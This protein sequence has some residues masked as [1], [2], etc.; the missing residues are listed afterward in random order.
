MTSHFRTGLMAATLLLAG[1]A[2]MAP[3]NDERR[4]MSALGLPQLSQS[5][6]DR[7]VAKAAAFPLGSKDNPV[8]ADGALGQRAYLTRLR[9]S[10]GR[11]PT[12][13]RSGNLG[14]GVYGTIVDAYDVAC[15]DG[16]TASV[17]MDLY[18]AGHVE[19]A[20]IPGFTI[21]PAG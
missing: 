17:I 15:A 6:M 3:Q 2:T 20:A 7:R 18:H 11:A 16:T 10:D 4:T 19:A 5:A 9:C 21:T 8:R 13:E 12:F 14:A 1:C